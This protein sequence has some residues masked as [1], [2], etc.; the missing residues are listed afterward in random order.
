MRETRKTVPPC[1]QEGFIE[2]YDKNIDGEQGGGESSTT[3]GRDC[4]GG[5]AEKRTGAGIA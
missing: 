1:H 4:A 3:I 2:L 5:A